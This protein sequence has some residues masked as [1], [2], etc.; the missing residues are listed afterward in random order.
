MYSYV[1]TGLI[2]TSDLRPYLQYWID[3]IHAPKK[4]A[5]DATWSAAL[6]TYI[7]VYR[8]DAVLSLF[9]EFDDDIRADSEAF[10]CFI[11]NVPD[12]ELAQKLNDAARHALQESSLR[13][14]SHL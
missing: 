4:D 7:A 12:Q 6:A 3:D 2:K 11:S 14:H 5:D 1:K 13:T 8:F 9:A 10:K